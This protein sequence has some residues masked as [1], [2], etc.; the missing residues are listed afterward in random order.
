[1][2]PAQWLALYGQT[3]LGV[4]SHRGRRDSRPCTALGF[5][6]DLGKS[7]LGRLSPNPLQPQHSLGVTASFRKPSQT[8]PPQCGVGGCP[9][10]R[11]HSPR[12]RTREQRGPG[13][14]TGSS[15]PQLAEGQ[16]AASAQSP[17]SGGEQGLRVKLPGR[18]GADA[19]PGMGKGSVQ[20]PECGSQRGQ[21]SPPPNPPG[22]SESGAR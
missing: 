22:V 20:E 10:P 11:P 8:Y 21:H 12:P 17:R 1:M 2:D 13:P 5:R 3:R 4:S 6:E 14:V 9:G 19:R 18:G 16:H 15:V 7:V